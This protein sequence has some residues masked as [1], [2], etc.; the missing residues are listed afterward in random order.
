MW[1]GVK[2]PVA[3]SDNLI[4]LM[5]AHRVEGEGWFLC[6]LTSTLVAWD[7]R[8]YPH[9]HNLK[10]CLENNRS[11]YWLTP[12]SGWGVRAILPLWYLSF[13]SSLMIITLFHI[14]TNPQHGGRHSGAISISGWVFYL[15]VYF[16]WLLKKIS[17]AWIVSLVVETLLCYSFLSSINRW[18]RGLVRS[19]AGHLGVKCP[20]F[21]IHEST[22]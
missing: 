18:M 12:G 1:L 3:T 2:V 11:Y 16:H 17:F 19:P 22:Q 8:G 6:P 20:R 14:K 7:T 21:I 9:T 13:K 4:L 5:V 15:H 10:K